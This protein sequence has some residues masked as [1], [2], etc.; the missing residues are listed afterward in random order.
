MSD[1]Y[2][3]LDDSGA[4]INA[5]VADQAFVDAVF[6]G[7]WQLVDAV[8][9]VVNLPEFARQSATRIDDAAA[10]IYA[11]VGRFMTEYEAREA[12]AVAY[13]DAGFTG[14]VPPRVAEFATPAGLDATTATN[15]ILS[16]AAALRTALEQL[17]GQRMRKYEVINAPDV[18]TAQVVEAD[19]LAR[20][21]A[22]GEA[23]K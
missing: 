16:Q 10:A 19:V 22:I 18:A 8:A 1:T 12:Q 21:K 4:V 2:H 11:R 23:V 6:P 3:I 7:K 15:L 5:I 14:T 20:I 9:P 17:S 13:R